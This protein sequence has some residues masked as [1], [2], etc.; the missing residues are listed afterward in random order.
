MNMCRNSY[1]PDC[2]S[3]AHKIDMLHVQELPT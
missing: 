2:T 1:R 3:I